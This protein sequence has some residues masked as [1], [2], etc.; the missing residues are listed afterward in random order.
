MLSS[1]C[2]QGHN[3]RNFI[4]SDICSLPQNS[5]QVLFTTVGL[6]PSSL[7]AVLVFCFVWIVIPVPPSHY[8]HLPLTGMQTV[9]PTLI[10]YP[11]ESDK[12]GNSHLGTTLILAGSSPIS[13]A[14]T[15]SRGHCAWSG[16]Q[17][18]DY[19]LV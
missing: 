5:L 7:L 13:I 9:F 2:I 3:C 15:R 6:K 4:Q 17:L 12:S 19:L 8:H 14:W 10:S 1:Q 11:G 16:L 18:I